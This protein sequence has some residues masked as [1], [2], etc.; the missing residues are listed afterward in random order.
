MN[1]TICRL[2]MRR[3]ER[4]RPTSIPVDRF[5]FKQVMRSASS[6]H[7]IIVCIM[8]FMHGSMAYGLSI[9]L[10]SI[11]NQLGFSP[12]RTQL[13]SAGPSAAGF[14]GECFENRGIPF[15]SKGVIH[16]LFLPVS[17]TSAYLSD[18]YRARGIIMALSVSLTVAGFALY[19]GNIYLDSLF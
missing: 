17:L 15:I 8:A 11:V 1:S 16:F 7:V 4:D 12:R 19:L 18:R 14:C 5:S 13:L 2:I 9:F 10:P 3:L 6:P